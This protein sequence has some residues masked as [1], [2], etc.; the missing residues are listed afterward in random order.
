MAKFGKL[1]SLFASVM[2]IASVAWS[3]ASV[4]DSQL[5]TIKN[6]KK[7]MVG[8]AEW[9]PMEY[10][11][12]TSGEVKGI[13]VTM[14]ND[15]AS[16]LGV[17]AEFLE[18]NWATLT[19]G[20]AANKFQIALM[21]DTDQRA[22]VVDF[23]VPLYHVPFTVIVKAD[24]SF[25]TFDDVNQPGNTIAVT[26]GSS[27][28]EV[29]T[30][31]ENKGTL[32]AKVLRLK[33]VGG[34]ILSLVSDQV[35]AFASSVDDLSQI[36]TQQPSLRIVD[37]NF[38]ASLFAVAVPKGDAELKAAIDKAVTDM[39]SDGTVAKLIKDNNMSGTVAGGQ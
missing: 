20:I 29:L 11:D 36:V 17:T 24:S 25:K 22:K 13:L 30:A 7:I 28:D 39:V 2:F 8:W 23:S 33:D 10:K 37:G 27:T 4:A 3:S 18:D 14:A 21:G 9:R 16:R 35:T 32:K 34:G 6:D 12:I 1:L 31:L 15:I 38:G 19:A 26:T 5:D